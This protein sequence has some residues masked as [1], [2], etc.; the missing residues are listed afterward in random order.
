MIDV[1][2][3]RELIELMKAH[4]LSAMDLRDGEVR[5]ALRRGAEPGPVVTAAAPQMPLVAAPAAAEIPP[6]AAAAEDEGLVPVT[7]P[8]VGTYY[9]QADPDSDPFVAIGDT[10]TEET[11]VCIIEAMK[12]FNEIKAEVAGVVE[13][14]LVENE[15]PVEYGQPLLLVRPAS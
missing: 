3:I 9:G 11:T 12:V 5:I 4:D 6:V 8:M 1:K 15:S 14:I 13:R 10:V 2:Q 7:S